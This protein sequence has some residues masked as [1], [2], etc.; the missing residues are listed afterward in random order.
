MRLVRNASSPGSAVSRNSLASNDCTPAVTGLV[1]RD[2]REQRV[3]LA[4]RLRRLPGG[5]LAAEEAR[6]LGLQSRRGQRAAAVVP[7]VRHAPREIGARG[8]G[9]GGVGAGHDR[10]GHVAERPRHD[11]HHA[12]AG[13]QIVEAAP[14]RSSPGPARARLSRPTRI[15]FCSRAGS[16]TV[17]HPRQRQRDAGGLEA[18][19]RGDVRG[20]SD[21]ARRRRESGSSRCDR[22][23]GRR[24]RR[25]TSRRSST[26]LDRSNVLAGCAPARARPA[27]RDRRAN[28]CASS[29][30]S[31]GGVSV[32]PLSPARMHR[33]R[34]RQT[35][36]GPQL[37]AGPARSPRS[38][39]SAA[40]G[41]GGAGD[42]A[43]RAPS[44]PW[45]RPPPRPRR[46]R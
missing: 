9:A 15:G 4:E 37:D 34:R 26:G 28:R 21:I 45:P 35:A 32:R 43:P 30:G 42:P 20:A 11:L 14:C 17:R 13:A 36:V 8:F 39:A 33:R 1:R 22:E 27:G 7:D 25:R 23:S 6:H 31:I 10:R 3:D 18:E 44:A 5:A 41:R 16:R 46:A 12:F 29:S 38:S 40:R 24:S 2:V 19:P